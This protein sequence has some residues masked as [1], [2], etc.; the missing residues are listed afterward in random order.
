MHYYLFIALQAFCIYHIYKNQ[1][2]YYWF[3]IIFFI[4]LVGAIIYLITHVFTSGD[5]NK[6]QNELTSI[7]NPTK[8]IKDFEKK[9][10]FSDTYASRVDL[11]DA[12]FE[13]GAYQN[14]IS[15][16]EKTLEDEVQNSVY[17]Y[18]QLILSYFQLK[19]FDNVL[20]YV[21]KIKGKPEFKGSKQQFCYGL[22]LREKGE[23]DLAEIQ[24]KAIDRP[25]SNYSERLQLAKFYWSQK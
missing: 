3:F 13:I 19:D 21:E 25:Y 23:L 8:K 2:S 7:V 10:Q 1:K 17:S 5:V 14:A 4:P 22:A 12:Y 18:Q 6:I 11:A 9:I 16:Y 20:R 24:L 15:N